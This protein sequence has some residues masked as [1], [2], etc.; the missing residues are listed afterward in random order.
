MSRNNKTWKTQLI[1]AVGK[2]RRIYLSYFRRG[3]VNQQR[4]RRL[5][6][7][8]RCSACCRFVFRCPFL[9][10]DDKN[11]WR[12]SI[13]SRRPRV[14]ADFPIDERDIRERNLIMPDTPCGFRFAPHKKEPEQKGD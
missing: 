4:A 1:L 7:C 2:L 11:G 12:C 6:E 9:V 13:H 8:Q 10:P 5:G 3:Y 14:C